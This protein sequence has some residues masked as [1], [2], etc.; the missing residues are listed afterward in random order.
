MTVRFVALLFLAA[1]APSAAILDPGD[2]LA[3]QAIRKALDDVPGSRFF[4]SWDFT[5]DPC[6]FSGVRCAGDRVVALSL[7]EPRAGSP[8]SPAASTP[9]QSRRPSPSTIAELTNLQFLALSRNFLSGVIPPAMG[10]LV[11]LRTLDLSFNQLSGSVPHELAAMPTLSNLV[12]AHNHL[13]GELPAFSS[14]ALVRLDLKHNNLNGVISA[15]PPSL[16]YLSLTWNRLSGTVEWLLPQLRRLN[17]LDLSVNHLTGPIPPP[18]EGAVTIPTVDLSYNQ[19]SGAIPPALATAKRLYLNN[20]RFTGEVPAAFVEK[21]LNATIQTLYLQ[22]NFLTGMELSP[23]AEMPVS[24]SLCLQYNCMVPPPAKM[25]CPPK[26]GS[27]RS[28]PPPSVPS[29]A[30]KTRI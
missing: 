7:G 24:S 27:R 28:G 29:G 11:R 19:L 13:S 17:H 23:A 25:T 3:L 9:P 4:S 21:L 20:N 26:A 14:P 8:A 2:F 5:A 18:P 6:G 1:V 12:L 15:L 22:H 10:S 16:E 30:D